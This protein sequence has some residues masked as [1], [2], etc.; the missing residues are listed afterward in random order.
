MPNE[1]TIKPHYYITNIE[2]YKNSLYLYP[3][4]WELE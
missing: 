1:K 2:R 4:D 3:S